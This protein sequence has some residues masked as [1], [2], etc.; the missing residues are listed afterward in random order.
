MLAQQPNEENRN[1]WLVL[2]CVCVC[3]G[4]SSRAGAALIK[5]ILG[6]PGGQS[7][8]RAG[9]ALIKQILGLP[10]GQSQVLK[11][12]FRANWRKARFQINLALG[13]PH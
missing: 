1:I 12:R 2:K 13:R 8:S 11:G 4:A 6:L 5:Q 3:Q 10:G 9:A 7:S